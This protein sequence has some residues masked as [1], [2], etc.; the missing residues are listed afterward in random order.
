[1]WDI[2]ISHGKLW[3]F[4]GARAKGTCGEGH[5]RNL[6]TTTAAQGYHV[7]RTETGEK[8]P[9]ASEDD[10]SQIPA[11]ESADVG[12]APSILMPVVPT[13]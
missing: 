12:K 9:K 10:E 6:A 13:H 2:H 11:G 3:S 8:E 7:R 4:F 1:M 5:A